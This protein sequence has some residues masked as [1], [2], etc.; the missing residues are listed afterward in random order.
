MYQDQNIKQNEK[1]IITI[2][3]TN[4]EYIIMERKEKD[5]Y[6]ICNNTYC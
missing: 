2:L 6:E 1:N 5:I 4:N 3:E